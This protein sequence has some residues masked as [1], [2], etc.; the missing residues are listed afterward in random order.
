VAERTGS[1]GKKGFDEPHG[2]SGGVTSV[3]LFRAMFSWLGLATASMASGAGAAV[4]THPDLVALRNVF[5]AIVL[6]WLKL[7]DALAAHALL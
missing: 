2:D 1:N 5:A 7:A 4:T 3:K 6:A